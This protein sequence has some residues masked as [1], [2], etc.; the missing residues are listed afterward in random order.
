MFQHCLRSP[1]NTIWSILTLLLLVGTLSTR[2]KKPEDIAFLLKIIVAC[3]VVTFGFFGW[4]K[5]QAV[6]GR[7]RVS[8]AQLLALLW[9]GGLFGA[10]AGML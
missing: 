6:L 1:P 9:S 8:E 10:W 7:G 5:R 4:D 3:N 2:G